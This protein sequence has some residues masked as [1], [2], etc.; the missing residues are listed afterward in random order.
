MRNLKYFLTN[1]IAEIWL[2]KWVIMFF[3]LA[4]KA[5]KKQQMAAMIVYIVA[6]MG[7]MIAKEISDLAKIIKEKN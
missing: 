7:F 3:I 5:E 1:I 4:L 6:A 2:S